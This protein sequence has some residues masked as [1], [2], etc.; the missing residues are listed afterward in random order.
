MDERGSMTEQETGLLLESRDGTTVATVQLSELTSGMMDFLQEQLGGLAQQGPPAPLALELSKVKFIDS[1][2][3][4]ALVVLLR[5]VK[6]GGGRLALVGLSGHCLNVME[7]TG[8]HKVFEMYDDVA[9]ALEA[10]KR[11]G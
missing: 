4:G 1:I 5:R 8:L 6:G 9:S 7:V 10:F 3:M 11:P 2:A